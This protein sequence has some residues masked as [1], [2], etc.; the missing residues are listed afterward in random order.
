MQQHVQA[1]QANLHP[2]ISGLFTITFFILLLLLSVL[3]AGHAGLRGAGTVA[4]WLGSRLS[5]CR[6]RVIWMP[7]YAGVSK[8]LI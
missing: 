8:L 3:C 6:V 2:L 4:D 1:R 7:R 5:S